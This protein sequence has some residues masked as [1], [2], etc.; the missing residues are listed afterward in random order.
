MA[1]PAAPAEAVSQSGAV[2][3]HVGRFRD[4]ETSTRVMF[5]IGIQVVSRSRGIPT[6]II[7]SV[8]EPAFPMT[9]VL[10]SAVTTRT[11]AP[12]G[13]GNVWA[14]NV[15]PTETA[16]IIL[17]RSSKVRRRWSLV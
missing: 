13:T 11:R 16:R 5:W 7:L 12:R 2:F 3:D 14:T 4:V 8:M 9:G 10:E 17:E 1:A 6:G 15:R